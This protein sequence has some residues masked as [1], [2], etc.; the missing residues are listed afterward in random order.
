M[1]GVI[2]AGPAKR[3]GLGNMPFIFWRCTSS[4]K[5]KTSQNFYNH[6]PDKRSAFSNNWLTVSNEMFK[7]VLRYASF[8]QIIFNK[9]QFIKKPTQRKYVSN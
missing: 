3:G 1:Q 5:T 4:L 6:F 8:L 2:K 7:I 9:R